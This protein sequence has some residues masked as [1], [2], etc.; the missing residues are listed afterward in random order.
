MLVSILVLYTLYALLR[1]FISLMQIRFL[2]R[3]KTGA[4]VLMSEKNY[5][6]AGEYALKK[7]QLGLLSTLLD[8]GL[9]AAWIL[10]GIGWLSTHLNS[11][12][13]LQASVLFLFGFMAINYIAALPFSIYQSFKLDK[14][15]GFSQMT[16][17]LFLIDQIKALLLFLIVGS[18]IFYALVWIV[19]HISNWWIWAFVL[20]FSI[21]LIINVIYPTIIA[22]LFNKFSPLEDGDLKTA[23]ENLMNNAGLKSDGIFKMDA[24]KRDKRLNAYFGGLG[25]TKRVVLFDTLLEKLDNNELLA[26]LGH[27]LGHFRHGDIWKNLIMM[28]LLLFIALAALGNLPDQLFV[29]M[30]VQRSAGVEIATMMLLLSLISFAFTPLMSFLSRRNE[31][32]AD[33]YGSKVGGKENLVSALIKLV[34]ENKAFPKAHPLVHFFYYTHPPILERLKELGYDANEIS[35]KIEEK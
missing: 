7:E 20:L 6:V 1:L 11:S 18:A 10:W 16:I 34:D 21:A 3:E 24:S 23:I 33:A 22:P 15:Y 19:I 25:K 12:T 13:A 8:L 27:E 28:A 31:Y 2:H 14:D 29:D 5:R 26:V 9:F 30:H 4:A 17:K 35:Q 32:A